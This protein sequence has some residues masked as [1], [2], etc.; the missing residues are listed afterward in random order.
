[1]KITEHLIQL[2]GV[3][4]GTNSNVYAIQYEGGVALVDCGYQEKQWNRM[5]ATLAYYQLSLEDIRHVFLTHAHFDHA[6]NVHRLNTLGVK[7]YSSK[8]DVEKIEIANPEMEKLFHSTWITGKVSATL[9]DKK[10]YELDGNTKITAIKAPGHSAGSFSF[11]IEVDNQK[12]LCTGDMFFVGPLPPEDDVSV[13]IGYMGSE[14][15]DF[16]ALV[17]SLHALS[18]IDCD[19]LLPGHYYFYRGND[20]QRV[21]KEACRKA[22]N[23]EVQD[24]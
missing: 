7:V 4:Y 10:T 12:C 24:G 14:D 17:D 16:K 11:L 3:Q 15:H 19:M 22:Q 1:M 13:E 21:L 5:Q 9:E 20:C 18:E 23:M 8:E 6:G 2:T